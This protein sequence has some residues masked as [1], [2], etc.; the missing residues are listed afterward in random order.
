MSY[1]VTRTTATVMIWIA[2]TLQRLN[3]LALEYAHVI[4]WNVDVQASPAKLTH[5][6]GNLGQNYELTPIRDMNGL[7]CTSLL[8]WWP[9]TIT[10]INLS[11]KTTDEE[12][13]GH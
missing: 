2:S 6:T 12:R 11:Y 8:R 3:P 7:S 13:S 9:Y 1:I 5:S 10:R 4:I